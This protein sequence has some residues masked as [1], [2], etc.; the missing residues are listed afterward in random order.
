MFLKES[1]DPLIVHFNSTAS[2]LAL[3]IYH[4]P[5]DL[6]FSGAREKNFRR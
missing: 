5:K 1:I 4:N 6:L 3:F 2:S